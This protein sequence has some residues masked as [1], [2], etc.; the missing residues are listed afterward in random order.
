MVANTGKPIM[1]WA[2]SAENLRDI[3]RIAAAAVGS[4]ETLAQR[5]IL[6]YF[7]TSLA[8]LIHTE[9]EVDNALWCAE[10]G[11]PVVYLGGGTAGVSAPVTGAGT[12]V[13]NLAAMLSGLAMIQLKRP[14]SSVC[15][16][17]VP[18]PMDPRTCRPSYGAPEMSLYSAAMA[19]ILRHLDLPFMGTAGAS[20][21]KQLDIQA[22]IES[23][24]Q[25]VFSALCG[26][27]AAHDVGFLDCADIGS[28]EMLVMNDEIINMVKR[29]VRGIEV[30]DETLMLDLIDRV[31]PGGDFL[32]TRHTAQRFRREIWLPGLLDRTPWALWEAA[33]RPTMARAIKD[34]LNH[35]LATHVPAP[36]P[37]G[38]AAEI[39]AVLRQAETRVSTQ[40]AP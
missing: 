7:T 36:L 30:S 27:T 6:A 20:E 10:Q 12:L 1:A 24:I 26:N 35:I 29:M 21:A 19:E 17:S 4:A 18:S 32:S 14:G 9:I 3:I 40:T 37:D 33:G 5:P 22:A 25:V 39:E 8:P 34:R 28:L 23:T 31:G 2:Y 16:G 13:I 38:A 11:I 15:L